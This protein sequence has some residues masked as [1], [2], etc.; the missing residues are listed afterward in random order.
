M[1]DVGV[2]RVIANAAACG[3]HV[4]GRYMGGLGKVFTGSALRVWS[5]EQ[6]V[7]SL[8]FITILAR[9]STKN[10]VNDVVVLVV[11][12]VAVFR[13]TIHFAAL[14]PWGPEMGSAFQV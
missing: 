4:C 5:R 13:R 8:L 7:R 9:V 10:H 2:R 3:L 6:R 11:V 1:I 14:G 12:V